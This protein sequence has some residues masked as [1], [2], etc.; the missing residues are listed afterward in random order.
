MRPSNAW[1]RGPGTNMSP[2]EDTPTRFE[3]LD[4][5]VNA[6]ADA[7]L[8]EQH[9]QCL[10]QVVGRRWSA[11]RRGL[12]MGDPLARVE[13]LRVTL[14]PG[15]RPVKGRPRVCN[16]IKAGWLSAC[17][18]SLA[19]LGFVVPN[20]RNSVGTVMATPKKVFFAY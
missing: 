16:P 18:A 7:G 20:M 8:E 1:K 19:A 15:A 11:F 13:P 4:N 12:R 10:R 14:K 9:M 17:I 5:A 3:A 2:E 6:S